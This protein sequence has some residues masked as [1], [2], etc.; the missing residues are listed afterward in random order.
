[1]SEGGG[2]LKTLSLVTINKKPRW[3]E[4]IVD[5]DKVLQIME[6]PDDDHKGTCFL[7]FS[8]DYALHIDVSM[9]QMRKI[10]IEHKKNPT[11]DFDTHCDMSENTM[12]KKCK[13]S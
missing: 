3:V 12:S 8:D 10:M 5:L 2:T 4:V 7:A 11:Q 13:N 9:K 1:M 6:Y